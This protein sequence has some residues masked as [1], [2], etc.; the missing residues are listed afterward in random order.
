MGFSK[1]K[2][3]F[4]NGQSE[5]YLKDYNI[6]FSIPTDFKVLSKLKEFNKN[7]SELTIDL[8]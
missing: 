8:S 4:T 5:R 2:Y 6:E 7:F 3:F 1:L